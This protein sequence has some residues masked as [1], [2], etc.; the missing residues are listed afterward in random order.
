ME[1]IMVEVTVKKSVEA[2]ALET[3]ELYECPTSDAEMGVSL[4][5]LRELVSK[6]RECADD[7]LV[8]I[9]TAS[10]IYVFPGVP[11][12]EYDESGLQYEHNILR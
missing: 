3:Q 2:Y 9:D 4:K 8:A 1:A 11:F 12:K 5:E 7:T 10:T 6:T